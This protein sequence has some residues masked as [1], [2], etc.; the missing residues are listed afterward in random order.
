MGEGHEFAVDLGA[1]GGGAHVRVDAEGKVQRRSAFGQGAQ[2]AVGREDVDLFAVEVELEVVEEVERIF[3]AALEHFADLGEPAVEV[4]LHVAVGVGLVFPVGGVAFFGHF[5]HA[6]RA[7]LDF[8]PASSRAHYRG[9]QRFV[10]VGLGNGDP[11][12]QAIRIG[13]VEVGHK[14]I[15]LPGIGFFLFE[16]RLE[17]D[18]DGEHVVDVLKGHLLL[19]HLVPNREDA[20]GAPLDFELEAFALQFLLDGQDELVHKPRTYRLGLLQLGDDLGVGLGFFELEREVFELGFDLVES[21]AVGQGRVHEQS[22]RGDLELLVARHGIQRAHVV[23]AVGEFDEDHPD[24]VAEGEQHLAEVLRLGRGGVVKDP[25]Y[26]G[27]PV[28]DLALFGA[29]QV[30]DV[31]QGD[32]G[33]LYGVVQQSTH[34]GGGAQPHFFGH[35]ARHGNGVVDVRLPGF[36]AHVFVRFQGNVKR[37]SNL[38]PI[39][40]GLAEFAR[41]QQPAVSPRD[42]FVLLLE[43]DFHAH[44]LSSF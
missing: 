11:V 35:D 13:L 28:D 2:V 34:N 30:L 15:H 8:H 31:L 29:K 27:E 38:T 1:H 12:A 20:F 36:A 43:V 44:L 14:G 23:Q 6:A 19:D 24:V 33:V 5:V 25:G 41:T 4:A 37:F 16:F 32:V 40:C 7:D 22:F 9:V 18:A 17:D 21:K 39:G 3:C 26:F 42:F 10:P